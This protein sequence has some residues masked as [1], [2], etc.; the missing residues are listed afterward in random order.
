MEREFEANISADQN[1]V[2][3]SVQ[4]S[5]QGNIAAIGFGALDVLDGLEIAGITPTPPAGYADNFILEDFQ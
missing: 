5:D 4:S 2:V 1:Y 3:R